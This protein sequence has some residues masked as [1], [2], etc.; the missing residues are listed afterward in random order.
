M[1]IRDG[2]SWWYRQYALGATEYKRLQVQARR[3]GRGS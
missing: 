1:L 2:L 3:A